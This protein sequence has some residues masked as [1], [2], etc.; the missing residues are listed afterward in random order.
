MNINSNIIFIQTLTNN[1]L[2]AHRVHKVDIRFR[3]T[4]RMN[5]HVAAH[6]DARIAR[7]QP[8]RRKHLNAG[9][10]AAYQLF[11]QTGKVDNFR[12]AQLQPSHLVADFARAQL[13]LVGVQL[14]GAHLGVEHVLTQVVGG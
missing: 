7:Y 2:I 4:A 1:I 10:W 8:Q 13:L 14:D 5:L 9:R 11:A 12:I 6:D 3:A